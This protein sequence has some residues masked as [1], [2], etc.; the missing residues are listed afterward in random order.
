MAI[1]SIEDLKKYEKEKWN[2]NFSPK[3]KNLLKSTQEQ[4]KELNDFD[5]LINELS[6]WKTDKNFYIFSQENYI[7]V[8]NYI[9]NNNLELNKDETF[10][11]IHSLDERKVYI[12]KIWI[13]DAESYLEYKT[14]SQPIYVYDKKNNEWY[15]NT[16]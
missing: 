15:D 7:K 12:K 9:K 8:F 3:I 14:Q 10:V 2:E 6:E 1:L 5:S 11:S 4:V 13:T 16:I